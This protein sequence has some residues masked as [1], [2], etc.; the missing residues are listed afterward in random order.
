MNSRPKSS[1]TYIYI[2]IKVGIR[3]FCLTYIVTKATLGS[4]FKIY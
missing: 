4:T 1:R 3:M 2:Y